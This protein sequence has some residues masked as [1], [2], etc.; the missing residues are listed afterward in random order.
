MNT[1]T[2]RVELHDASWDD[3]ITLA[4]KL[5]HQGVVDV[6]KSDDGNWYKMP[7]AE[8][9]YEGSADIHQVRTVVAT[10]AAQVVVRYAVFV[11]ESKRRA[12]Q[13]LEVVKHSSAA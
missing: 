8:Y 3:Y 10:I 13:G 12:W 9:N 1:Y 6:I 7:P 5:A 4:A 11:T 2:I